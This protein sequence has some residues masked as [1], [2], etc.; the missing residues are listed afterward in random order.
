M[1]QK[2]A[3]FR[4]KPFNFAAALLYL[5]GRLSAPSLPAGLPTGRYDYTCM[6]AFMGR[7]FILWGPAA[8]YAAKA[9]INRPRHSC[10][11]RKA[12]CCNGAQ[13]LAEPPSSPDALAG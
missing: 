4:P 6:H 3:A 7:S 1:D 13:M 10:W 9:F 11:K 2:D 8:L 5:F 12:R